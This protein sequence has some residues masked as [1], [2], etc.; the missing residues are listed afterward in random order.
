MTNTAP[1]IH[2][3]WD[4]GP[5]AGNCYFDFAAMRCGRCDSRYCYTACYAGAPGYVYVVGQGYIPFGDAAEIEADWE[6]DG[7]VRGED[8][9]IHHGLR[10]VEWDHACPSDDDVTDQVRIFA[11]QS[12]PTL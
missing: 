7:L 4:F 1:E 2:A 5:G 8:F 12:E 3:P 9:G 11:L 6:K 10:R